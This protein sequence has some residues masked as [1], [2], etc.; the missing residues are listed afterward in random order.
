MEAVHRGGRLAD[1]AE[2]DD[3]GVGVPGADYLEQADPVHL[4][5]AHVRNDERGLADLVE[6]LERF[7]AAAGLEA[8]EALGLEHAPE[9]STH[10]G[11]IIHDETLGGAG[12]D[13]LRVLE[14]RHGFTVYFR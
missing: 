4:G 10:T 8:L 3:G 7:Q 13:R 9:K 11:L 5:H 2:H 1:A 12:H 6:H 14:C